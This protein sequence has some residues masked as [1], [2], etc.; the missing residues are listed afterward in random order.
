MYII[1]LTVVLHSLDTRIIIFEKKNQRIIEKNKWKWQE[2]YLKL[3]TTQLITQKRGG[4][5]RGILVISVYRLG[6]FLR[7]EGT[8]EGGILW[9]EG[10]LL[11]SLIISQSN[12][13]KMTNSFISQS[14]VVLLFLVTHMRFWKN[15]IL[16]HYIFGKYRFVIYTPKKM[17]SK[18][19]CVL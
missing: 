14:L 15:L 19:H 17:H 6:S 11:L 9:G 1:F 12:I 10:C 16:S 3:S 18:K 13:K 8:K 2:G 5:S 7:G 4:K